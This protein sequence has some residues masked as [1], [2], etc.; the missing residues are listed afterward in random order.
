MIFF[1]N[2]KKNNNSR[3]IYNVQYLT[4]INSK[5]KCKIYYNYTDTE[6][7][8]FNDFS[9]QIFHVSSQCG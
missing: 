3:S 9:C 8:G 5:I 4:H 7:P 2:K 1:L 6:F